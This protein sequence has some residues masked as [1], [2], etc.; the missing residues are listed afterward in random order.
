MMTYLGCGSGLVIGS[1]VAARLMG[2]AGGLVLL[3][4][5]RACNTQVGWFMCHLVRLVGAGVESWLVIASGWLLC[6]WA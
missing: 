2:V 6:S 1:E 4:W 3:S 5:M